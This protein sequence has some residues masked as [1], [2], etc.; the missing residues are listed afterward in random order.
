MK[1]ADNTQNHIYYLK[2][3]YFFLIFFIS[4]LLFTA[5]ITFLEAAIP[6]KNILINP[7]NK[8]VTATLRGIPAK[9]ALEEIGRKTGIEFIGLEKITNTID[10]LDI[11]NQSL[12][13]AI[14][15]IGEDCIFIF[16]KEGPEEGEKELKKVII[17]AQKVKTPPPPPPEPPKPPEPIQPPKITP[18]PAPKTPPPPP[19]PIIKPPPPPPPPK[20]EPPKPAPKPLPPPPAEEKPCFIPPPLPSGPTKKFSTPLAP[21]ECLREGEKYYNAKRWDLAVKNFR[22]YLE[23]KPDDQNIKEKIDKANEFASEA[24]RLYKSAK[25]EVDSCNLERAYELYQKS[26]KLYPLLYDTWERILELK[27]QCPTCK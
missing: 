18:P 22:C 21:E 27:K 2:K 25:Q 13:Q 26:Y 7:L 16:R 11:R 3:F 8:T 15:E 19:K 9:E 23:E 24:I 20:V 10:E 17:L 4:A 6:Q 14:K 1:G 12:E 5:N